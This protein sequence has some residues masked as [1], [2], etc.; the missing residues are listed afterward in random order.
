MELANLYH[1]SADLRAIL[2]PKAPV[3][4]K[5]D[6]ATGVDA[7]SNIDSEQVYLFVLEVCS[8]SDMYLKKL[9]QLERD[10]EYARIFF[11]KSEDFSII[12]KV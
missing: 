1:D 11:V 4:A 7:S 2:K 3:E 9:A 10:L 6:G 12:S 5:R 8:K